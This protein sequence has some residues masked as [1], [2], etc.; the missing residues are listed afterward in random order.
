V[1][2][3]LAAFDEMVDR[4]NMDYQDLCMRLGFDVPIGGGSNQV[5]RGPPQIEKIGIFESDALF[6][7]VR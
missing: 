7:M 4:R 2:S 5:S 1:N 6:W 3:H